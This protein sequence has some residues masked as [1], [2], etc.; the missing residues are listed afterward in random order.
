ML[1]GAS[2]T[3]FW[4]DVGFEEGGLE[5]FDFEAEAFVDFGA[6]EDRPAA[7]LVFGGGAPFG[8]AFDFG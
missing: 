8:G 3:S 5:L 7:A 4:V 1:T 6:E 2:C